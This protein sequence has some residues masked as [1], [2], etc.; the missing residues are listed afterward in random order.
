MNHEYDDYYPDPTPYEEQIDALVSAV[1]ESVHEDIRNKLERLERENAE[2][3]VV[4]RDFEKIKID[5]R[6]KENELDMEKKDLESKVR[7]ERLLDLMKDFEIELF[8]PSTTT[9]KNPKCEKCDETRRIH[10]KSPSG[11]DMY[12][13]CECNFGRKVFEPNRYVCSSFASISGK[14]TA[15]YKPYSDY[16]GMEYDWSSDAPAFIYNGEDYT[17]IQEMYRSVYF[18]TVE[19]CQAYCDWLT[20]KEAQK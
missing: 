11:K 1:K 5:Y 15:W 14:F 19:E 3:Q 6:R 13:S 17:S 20:E 10:F 16:D 18:K 7:R 9:E 2:L 4:K 8:R 12:E